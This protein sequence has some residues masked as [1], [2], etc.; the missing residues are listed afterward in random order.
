MKFK[1]IL[2]KFL[3]NEPNKEKPKIIIDNEESAIPIFNI[4][5]KVIPLGITLIIG[6]TALNAMNN[7]LS[8]MLNTSNVSNAVNNLD[9]FS[10]NMG[11]QQLTKYVPKVFFIAMF[12]AIFYMVYLIYKN[13]Y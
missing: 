11:I 5:I 13:I 2:P 6:I 1:I 10:D 3:T 8:N 4:L 7:S 12:F 9:N